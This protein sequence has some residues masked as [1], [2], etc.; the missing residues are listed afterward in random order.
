[1]NSVTLKKLFMS[2]IYT[3]VYLDEIDTFACSCIRSLCSCCIKY[4]II[5]YGFTGFYS[6]IPTH[7]ILKV[8]LAGQLF[9][10]IYIYYCKCLVTPF[11]LCTFPELLWLLCP[12]YIE[13]LHMF[14]LFRWMSLSY[15]MLLLMLHAFDVFLQEELEWNWY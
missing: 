5:Q 13:A 10:Y 3:K 2:F 1:M 11:H 9:L 4:K 14:C 6:N 12:M 8:V 15:C 7:I